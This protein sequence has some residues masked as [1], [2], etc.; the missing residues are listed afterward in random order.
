MKTLVV[1]VAGAADRPVDELRGR[2]P[3]EAATTPSLD[4][5]AREGRVGRLAVAPRAHRAAEGAFA[6]GMF[7]LD[8]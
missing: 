7:G 5:M 8:P 3:L 2:T 1:I 4:R 6:L